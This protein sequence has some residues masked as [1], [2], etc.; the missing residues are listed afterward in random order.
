MTLEV[1]YI[2]YREPDPEASELPIRR[3]YPGH[4]FK[5]EDYSTP[6]IRRVITGIC[7]LHDRYSIVHVEAA[8]VAQERASG[9]DG[10]APAADDVESADIVLLPGAIYQCELAG[11]PNGQITGALILEHVQR[12]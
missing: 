1:S 12:S 2:D 8:A 4:K 10:V 6:G 5:H 11:S 9:T 7:R 3:V